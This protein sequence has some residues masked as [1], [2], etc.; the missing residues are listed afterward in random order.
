MDF[1]ALAR[2]RY[3]VRKFKPNHL[4]QEKIDA[5]LD[6]ANIAP[7]GCNL[8]PQR[9]LVLNTDSAMEKLKS[10]T[11]CHF[12]APSAMLVCFNEQECWTRKYDGEKSGTVDA[13]IVATHIMLKA[14]EEGI[15]CCWVMH[16]D[17]VKMRESFNIPAHIKPVALLVMGIPHE[18]AAPIQM[19][20]DKR[21]LTDTV[22]FDEF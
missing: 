3:S 4:P 19:H 17:P 7:T 11:R 5:L 20:F 9:I 13:T 2:T 22:V 12:D 6:I 16:F 21:P 14:H 18:D 15:G 8:Q 1:S 10:C